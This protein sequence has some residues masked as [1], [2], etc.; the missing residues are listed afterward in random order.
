VL[1]DSR[2][3]ATSNP[4]GALVPCPRSPYSREM[5]GV[6][7]SSGSRPFIR[8]SACTAGACWILFGL[9]ACGA[10]GAAPPGGSAEPDAAEALD[11]AGAETAKPRPVDA[12][13]SPSAGAS[14]TQSGFVPL[15]T[16]AST[17]SSAAT[18][19]GPS[20]PVPSMSA[21]GAP[22]PW[23]PVEDALNGQSNCRERMTGTGSQIQYQL[24]C[25]P[26][27]LWVRCSLAQ[28]DAIECNCVNETTGQS[29]V[30]TLLPGTELETAA[31]SS[32]A[33][34][35]GSN[36]PE[37]SE[38]ECEGTSNVESY[39]C[40]WSEVCT[41]TAELAE[42]L[43]ATQLTF[44]SQSDCTAQNGER[45]LCHC[46]GTDQYAIV[47]GTNSADACAAV[48]PLCRSDAVPEEEESCTE[49]SLITDS[50]SCSLS[51][52]C[53]KRV[54]LDE[55]GDVYALAE[56]SLRDS[57]CNLGEGGA[58]DCFCDIPAVGSLTGTIEATVEEACVLTDE[59]C[60]SATP[61][62]PSGP[63]E[64]DLAGAEAQGGQ[65]SG[66]TVCYQEVSHGAAA[67]TTHTNLNS[68]CESD[69]NGGWSCVCNGGGVDTPPETVSAPNVIRA[70]LNALD[71]CAARGNVEI[72]ESG[73]IS[74]QFSEQPSAVDAG[75]SID[76]VDATVS[77]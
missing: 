13:V 74:I 21:T 58:F 38:P 9:C 67:L 7:S 1:C 71:S 25:D 70:C 20:M 2:G 40:I 18:T 47:E 6:S 14:A 10:D 53:G 35:N 64:C 54:D 51:R 49:P 24:E 69:G 29:R 11:A 8:A 68:T 3:G 27:N 75:N 33:L 22:D 23:T 65:C 61:P 5:S 52:S 26:D 19:A 12:A 56:W 37:F 76:L 62:Q 48:L 77:P 32:I 46:S 55:T 4:H 73:Y 57:Y 16:S 63:L 50:Y 28:D 42:G 43:E 44:P 59:V 45:S 17:A 41:S 36:A 31:R 60:N 34:C 72:T 30:Y 15:P 39:S 66:W